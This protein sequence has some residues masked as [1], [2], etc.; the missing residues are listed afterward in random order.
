MTTRGPVATYRLQLGPSFGFEQAEAILPYL[1]RLGISDIY[2]SPTFASRPGSTHGYDVIDMNCLNPE[3]GGREGFDRLSQSVARQGLSWLQDVVPNHNAFHGTNRNLMDVLELGPHSRF[4][5]FY[6]ILWDHPYENINGKIL[7][8]FLGDF[9]ARCLERGELQLSY[10]EQGFCISYYDFV[11]PISLRSYTQILRHDLI[12]L[13]S[14]PRTPALPRLVALIKFIDN[15]DVEIASR[16]DFDYA[17]F[18]K[19]ILRELY[20]GDEAIRRHVDDGIAAFNGNGEERGYE[21]LDSLLGEQYF[22]LSY[23]K[24]GTEELNYRR[25]FSVND[26]ISLRVEELEVFEHTHGLLFELIEAGQV[27]GVRIDHVD[28]LYDPTGYLARLRERFPRLYI[29]VEKILEPGEEIPDDWPVQGTTGYDFLDA[30]CGLIVDERAARALERT[31]RAFSRLEQPYEQIVRDNKRNIVGKHMA[32]DIDNLAL[33]LKGITNRSREG[34]DLTMYAVR[35]ALVEILTLF[36]IYRTYVNRQRFTPR[37]LGVFSQVIETGQRTAHHFRNEL[38][39]IGSAIKRVHSGELGEPERSDW[40]H[41]IMRLQQYTGPLMAKG[42]EDSSFYVYNRLVARNEVGCDPSRLG[43]DLDAF[44]GFNHRRFARWPLSMNTT[45]THDTKRG[46]DT[47]AR[48]A[49]IS[50]DPEEWKANLARWGKLNRRHKTRI[51]RRECPSANDEY[52]LYQTM[53]GAAPFEGLDAD[54]FRSRLETYLVK[55]AREAKRETSWLNPDERYEEALVAFARRILDSETGAPFLE[56]FLPYL[57]RIAHRGV[58]ASLAQTLLKL[59]CPGVPDIYQGTE[60]WD[61]SLVDPDNRRPVDFAR[62]RQLLAELLERLEQDRA[63]LLADL[64]D[65]PR[66]GRVK[67]LLI[68]ELLRLRQERPAVFLDG[69]YEPVLASGAH[70]GRVVAFA[71]THGEEIVVVVALR[72]VNHLMPRHPSLRIDPKA[73]GDTA[74]RLPWSPRPGWTERFTG[75]RLASMEAV[76]LAQLVGPLPFAVLAN[77]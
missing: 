32:G 5:R 38:E 8:P 43:Y 58:F 59:T 4:Y 25:F 73:W 19:E 35:R 11:L 72:L 9:Y 76:G 71:R 3:I 30:V 13:S 68:Q 50:W 69:R 40:T 36:P 26:L 65:D 66:D 53:L 12:R 22:R 2:S 10:G 70:G 20:D 34:N 39:L 46:E 74:L 33:L 42:V 41:F 16:P 7:A 51:V 44:H 64:A 6:D 77:W 31:Y 45:A 18:I 28:G 56:L 21:L 63:A 48:I 27:H 57:E 52:L 24:V 14:G 17:A 75:V 1:A 62:R 37:D 47:R 61:L 23:W 49:A 54:D 60:L 15:L 67:L 55:A 29:V